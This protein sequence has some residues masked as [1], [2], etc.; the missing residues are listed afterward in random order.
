MLNITDTIRHYF[1]SKF[2]GVKGAKLQNM[3]TSGEHYKEEKQLFYNITKERQ[4]TRGCT[5]LSLCTHIEE[6]EQFSEITKKVSQRKKIQNFV[7]LN[8]EFM[9]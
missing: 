3:T 7:F 8:P 5:K 4:E 1:I 6:G 9:V 2:W